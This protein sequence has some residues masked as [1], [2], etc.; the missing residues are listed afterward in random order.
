VGFLTG[1]FFKRMNT[2]TKTN[3]EGLFDEPTGLVRGAGSNEEGLF[4][5]PTGLVRE[6]P[7]LIE[8]SLFDGGRDVAPW[9]AWLESKRK[10][11]GK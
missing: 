9:S 5:E 6:D 8:P 2:K 1:D 4:D 10:G 7:F 11:G 3:E